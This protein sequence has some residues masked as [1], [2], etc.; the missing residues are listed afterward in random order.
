MQ[1]ADTGAVRQLKAVQW[2]SGA[3]AASRDAVDEERGEERGEEEAPAR[4]P[5]KLLQKT[6]AQMAVTQGDSAAQ[7]AQR[8][9][10]L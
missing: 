1:L 4:V 6:V 2:S 3:R 9:T 5:R 10:D 8:V 7:L